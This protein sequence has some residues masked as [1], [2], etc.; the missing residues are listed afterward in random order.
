MF[1]L[2]LV[3][4][5]FPG[6]RPPSWVLC[7]LALGAIPPA[8]R[9][10]QPPPTLPAV[11]DSATLTPVHGTTPGGAFLRAVLVPGW[12]HASIGSYR[13]GAFYFVAEGATAWALVK[14]DRRVRDARQ[15][16]RFREEVVRARL[17]AEGVTEPAEITAALDED[18]ALVDLRN[19]ENARRQQRE[20]W[21]A[22]GIFLMFLSG[23]DAYVSS[24]LQ[25]FPTPIE[26]EA[27]PMGD[28]RME[29]SVGIKLPR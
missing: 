23:A 3:P 7:A 12:G 27:A 17:I 26:L 24:H 5:A 18:E 1:A 16:I 19:L 6:A 25:R 13:R 20:D 21:T 28:G 2:R 4:H 9:A 14:A 29:L 15:R 22:L 8:V 11:T 10:Q